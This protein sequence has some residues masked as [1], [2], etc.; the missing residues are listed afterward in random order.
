[1]SRLL[2]IASGALRPPCPRPRAM[3]RGRILLVLPCNGCVRLG[4]YML[5][6]SWGLVW[7]R[8]WDL[9]LS[10]VLDLAAVDS[11]KPGLVYWGEERGL[12]WCDLNPRWSYYG[13]R[14]WRLG[15]LE[16][17]LEADLLDASTLYEA[18]AYYVNV[19]AYRL[20]IEKASQ[21]LLRAG[22]RIIDAGPRPPTLLGFR[23]RENLARLRAVLEGLLGTL[24]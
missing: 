16:R 6:D 10:G 7:R 18:I 20:A 3:G 15:A 5:C 8:V 21:R 24:S 11:C 2:S 22:Y 14:P 23:S 1:L 12:S 4:D 9:V 17:A 13:R 19:K